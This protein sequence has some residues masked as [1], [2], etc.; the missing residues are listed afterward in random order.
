MR[1]ASAFEFPPEQRRALHAARRLEWITIAYL[2]SVT[3]LMALVMGAS[4]AMRTAWLE[5]VLSLVPPIVFLVSDRFRERPPDARF[6][7]GYHR[8]T[9]IAFLCA[10]VALTALGLVLLGSGLGHLLRAEHPTIGAVTLFGRTV[11]LGWLM[12]PV[13]LWSAVPA[14]LLGRAKLP[15]AESMHDKV[16]HTDATTNK[17]DWM[18]AGAAMIGVLGI[19]VGWWWMDAAAAILISLSITRDGLGNLREV[20]ANLMDQAPKSTDHSRFDPL[21]ARVRER[22]ERLPWVAQA[23]VRMHEKGHVYFGEVFVVPAE[24]DDLVE[25]LADARRACEAM[26]WRVHEILLVPVEHL[27]RSDQDEPPPGDET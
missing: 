27:S 9:S 6:P 20:V 12:L 10:S 24:H 4:Q 19:G 1:A 3:I 18:T 7:Y 13:L 8:V 11:W 25:R 15:L 21:P 26:S 5:D 2:A 22:V 16:L 14:F 23:Q 17:A